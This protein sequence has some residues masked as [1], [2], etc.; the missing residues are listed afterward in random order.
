MKVVTTGQYLELVALFEVTEAYA[1]GLI[2]EL[3]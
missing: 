2:F 1:T 3:L